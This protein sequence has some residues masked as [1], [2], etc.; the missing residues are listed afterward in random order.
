[1]PGISQSASELFREEYENLLALVLRRISTECEHHK[2]ENIKPHCP[3]LSDYVREF[4]RLLLIV[5]KYNLKEALKDEIRWYINLFYSKNLGLNGINLII[6]SWLMTIQGW[7]KSPE[8]NELS[9]LLI[10]LKDEI[11]SIIE[12]LK[13]IEV[14]TDKNVSELVKLL[15]SGESDRTKSFIKEILNTKTA[16]ELI[17]NLIIPTLETIGLLWEK[18]ELEI[19]EEHLATMNM[20]EILQ[21]ITFLSVP[22]K[23]HDKNLLISCV[24]NDEHDLIATALASYLQIKGWMLKNLGRGLPPEQIL[25]AVKRFNPQA[26]ILVFTMISRLEGTLDTISLVKREFPS[27]S[28]IIGGR[29]AILAGSVLAEKGCIVVNSFN[30]CNET[31]LSKLN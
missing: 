27:L 30:E 28:I 22:K 11:P 6:D 13:K 23:I 16:D 25:K 12:K 8:C 9:A 26:L 3:F 5:F 17:T 1:M 4:G 7:L 24:P 18:N 10:E 19:F 21:Y 15:I 31:L 20:K 29:G 14:I 2:I